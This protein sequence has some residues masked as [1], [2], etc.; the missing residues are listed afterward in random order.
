MPHTSGTFV[1]CSLERTCAKG[2]LTEDS[3]LILYKSLAGTGN[4]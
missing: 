3:T 1:T 2:V 4:A